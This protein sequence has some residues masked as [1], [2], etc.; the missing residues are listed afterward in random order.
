MARGEA[1]LGGRLDGGK[2]EQGGVGAAEGKEGRGGKGVV[3]GAAR[4]TTVGRERERGSGLFRS[5]HPI[6]PHLISSQAPQQA[7]D[8]EGGHWAH[9][10]ITEE[11]IVFN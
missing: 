7:A 3:L 8:V 11:P 9:P 2:A 6:A 5:S 1:G 10:L 4:C